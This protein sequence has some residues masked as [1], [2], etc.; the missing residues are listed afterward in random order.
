MR[1]LAIIILLLS[2]FTSSY[3]QVSHTKRV[4]KQDF[5]THSRNLRTAG[6]VFLGIGV[7][8][9]AIAAP[10]NVDFETLGYLVIIGGAATLASIPLFIG[11]GSNK[12]KA[13]KASA[14]IDLQKSLL[15]QPNSYAFHYY[16]AVKLK[17]RL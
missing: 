4:T 2:L 7:T 9:L 16:P 15:I 1:K 13:R 17:F 3:S 5:L 6:F 8:C 12:R 10:G 14:E 11:A